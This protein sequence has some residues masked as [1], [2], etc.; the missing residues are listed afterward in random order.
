MPCGFYRYRATLD[1]IPPGPPPPFPP[2]LLPSEARRDARLP[3]LFDAGAQPTLEEACGWAPYVIGS[4]GWLLS[5]GS[6]HM[7]P[8]GQSPEHLLWD[9]LPMRCS[10]C[11]SQPICL[12]LSLAACL[13]SRA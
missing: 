10:S 2:E 11:A 5:L 8:I 4:F 12:R 7:D 6:F 13:L 9:L 3:Y 1:A